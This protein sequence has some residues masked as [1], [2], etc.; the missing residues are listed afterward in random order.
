MKENKKIFIIF[1]VIVAM[2]FVSWF[3]FG[4]VDFSS[5]KITSKQNKEFGP[6]TANNALILNNQNITP[7]DSDPRINITEEIGND[8]SKDFISKLNL[9]TVST[10]DD[11]VKEINKNGLDSSKME[12]FLNKNRLQLYDDSQIT[13]VNEDKDNSD[14]KAQAYAQK[15]SVIMSQG[16]GYIMYDATKFSGAI[17]NFIEQGKED[18]LDR[19]IN[20]LK[21]AENQLTGVIVPTEIIDFH[22]KNVAYLRNFIIILEAIKTGERDPL[23]AYLAIT[24]GKDKIIKQADDINALFKILSSKYKI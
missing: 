22:K 8:I 1:G 24:Q 9:S 7:S 15:Y 2:F 16:I 19:I 3:V 12:E 5:Q 6:I 17:Q 20:D 4:I 13:G 18:D 10:T 23:R 11:L 21:I 14:A